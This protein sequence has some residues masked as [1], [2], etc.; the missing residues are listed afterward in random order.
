[1]FNLGDLEFE[2]A[3]VHNAQSF[4]RMYVMKHRKLS[5]KAFRSE[6]TKNAAALDRH[7]LQYYD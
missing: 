6:M 7:L 2:S 1:M 4:V 3:N 5:A